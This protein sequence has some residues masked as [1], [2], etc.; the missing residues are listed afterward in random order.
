MLLILLLS[1]AQEQKKKFD[2][3]VRKPSLGGA[4]I[5]GLVDTLSVMR[6]KRVW[7]TLDEDGHMTLAHTRPQSFK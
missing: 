6:D 4:G 5:S 3:W 7:K 1:D 2:N